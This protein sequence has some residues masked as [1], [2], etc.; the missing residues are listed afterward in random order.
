MREHYNESMRKLEEGLPYLI[1]HNR[2]H[3]EE[4]EKWI[5]RAGRANQESAA[6]DLEK[7]L[8]LSREIT[9]Y[10]EE[11]LRKVRAQ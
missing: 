9:T 10:L 3:A 2:E 5:E 7:V 11:A 6:E 1:K 8:E 4:I